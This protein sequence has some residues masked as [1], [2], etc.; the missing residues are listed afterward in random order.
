MR[1]L[2]FRQRRRRLQQ[3]LQE[4]WDQSQRAPADED[5]RETYRDL[6]RA[7]I[8]LVC[9]SLGKAVNHGGILRLAEAYRIERV[10][11]EMEPDRVKDFSG[12]RGSHQ[13]QPWAWG[14]PVETI[15]EAKQNGHRIYGLS[16]TEDAIPLQRANW[17]FPATVALGHELEGIPE[18]VE[19]LCDE[20]LAI[21]LYGITVSLNVG[22]AAAIALDHALTAYQSQNPTY[23]PARAASRKLLDS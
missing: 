21:P 11:Y 16:L 3:N 9:C 19:A 8:Q 1:R 7:E 5:L 23:Q 22:M 18:P 6:P 4:V 2:R 15:T 13:W 20:I 12:V 10:V 14:D 17:Q